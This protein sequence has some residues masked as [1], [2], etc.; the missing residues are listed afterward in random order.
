MQQN[1]KSINRGKFKV[2]LQS[3]LASSVIGLIIVLVSPLFQKENWW[4]YVVVIAIPL[5]ILMYLRLISIFN[6]SLFKFEL[7]DEHLTMTSL[8]GNKVEQFNNDNHH[9]WIDIHRLTYIGI[10]IDTTIQLVIQN[11]GKDTLTK[12]QK[13]RHVLLHGYNVKEAKQLHN[14]INKITED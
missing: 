14:Y 9:Y 6:K 7:T 10:P 5:S 2:V 1:Q 11:Q 12:E 3:L 8:K 4:V 13:K